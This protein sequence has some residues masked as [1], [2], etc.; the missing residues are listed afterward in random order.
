MEKMYCDYLIIVKH[1]VSTAFKV[2][3]YPIRCLRMGQFILPN[4]M[5]QTVSLRRIFFMTYKMF[6]L[7]SHYYVIFSF[8]YENNSKQELDNTLNI[9][10]NMVITSPVKVPSQ[11]NP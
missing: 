1:N 5:P 10:I 6:I 3:K 9:I 8:P 2:F 7:Y 4:N 11:E